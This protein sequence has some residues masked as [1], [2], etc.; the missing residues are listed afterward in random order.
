MFAVLSALSAFPDVTPAEFRKLKHSNQSF[1]TIFYAPWCGH[2][3]AFKPH[4][5]KASE[6]MKNVVD[7]VAIDCDKA[8]NKEL[9]GQMD[10]KGFPTVKMFN[11][12]GKRK[13]ALDFTGTRD[14]TSLL[15]WVAGNHRKPFVQSSSAAQLAQDTAELQDFVVVLTQAQKPAALLYRLAR[16]YSKL[17]FVVKTDFKADDLEPLSQEVFG[18]LVK[19]DATNVIVCKAKTQCVSFEG[20]AGFEEIDA[21]MEKM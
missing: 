2:C 18:K 14:E 1:V 7:L 4:F 17:A 13:A 21:W 16:K 15:S 19:K 11:H 10:V 8:T 3:N 6:K 5:E 12:N 9:C 20:K